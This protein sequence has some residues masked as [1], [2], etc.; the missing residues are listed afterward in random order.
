VGADGVRSAVRASMTSAMTT[1]ISQETIPTFEDKGVKE[2][3]PYVHDGRI[4]EEPMEMLIPGREMMGYKGAI[5]SGFHVYRT[6]VPRSIIGEHC[7]FSAA[8][9]VGFSSIVA[10]DEFE[11]GC[12]RYTWA[13]TRLVK[14]RGHV[15]LLNDPFVLT[16]LIDDCGLPNLA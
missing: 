8:I 15:S 12:F 1:A 7:A 16:I 2:I 14:A 3:V 9:S 5:W 13:R 10:S 4:I 11:L 6:V